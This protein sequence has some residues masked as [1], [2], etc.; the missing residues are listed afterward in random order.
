M[1]RILIAGL[2]GGGLLFAGGAFSHMALNFESRA[3]KRLPDEPAARKFIVNQALHAGIYSFP[4]LSSKY[5]QMTGAEQSAEESRIQAEFRAGPAGMFV[6]APQGQEMMGARQ[7]VGELI[8]DMV[9]ALLAAFVAAHFTLAATF[10]RR[11]LLIILLAPISWLTL[12][13]SFELW[14]RFPMAFIRDGLFV[15]LIEWTLAGGAIAAI[16]RPIMHH[17]LGSAAQRMGSGT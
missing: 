6:L 10:A 5:D 11:W 16:V 2:V 15:S 9:A 14:Y 17:R 7:L 12:T 8:G 4:A 1:V 3:F 13:L